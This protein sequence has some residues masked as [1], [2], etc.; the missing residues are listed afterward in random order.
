MRL[1]PPRFLGPTKSANPLKPSSNPAATRAPGLVPPGRSQSTNTSHNETV[2]TSRAVTPEGTVR[3]AR[4]TPPFPTASSKNP[5]MNDIRQ[6]AGVGRTPV[7]QRKMGYKI[8]P[9]SR[10]REPA[11]K[12]G[13]NDSIPTRIARYVDPHTTYTSPNAI[14]TGVDTRPVGGATTGGDGTGSRSSMAVDILHLSQK[15]KPRRLMPP[16]PAP[17]WIREYRDRVRDQ[18]GS[19]TERNRRPRYYY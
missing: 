8:K 18:Q 17:Y 3:S 6:C 9:A 2:A 11:N 19:S 4:Q 10:W 13:G 16:R 5:V 15:H 7:F 1:V 14:I 12:S